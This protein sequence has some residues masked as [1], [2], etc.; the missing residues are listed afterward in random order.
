MQEKPWLERKMLAW[1]PFPFQ[2]VNKLNLRLPQIAVKDKLW[3]AF[4]FHSCWRHLHPRCESH[5]MQMQT[6]RLRFSIPST[7][8]AR[9]AGQPEERT[10]GQHQPSLLRID[11]FFRFTLMKNI[12]RYPQRLTYSRYSA[13]MERRH[14]KR[15]Q[16]SPR[17][18]MILWFCGARGAS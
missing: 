15:E 1:F 8:A 11:V 9:E 18:Q 6:Q 4:P 12:T 10:E 5:E 2:L 14:G 3:K 17:K 16:N 13:C 7:R